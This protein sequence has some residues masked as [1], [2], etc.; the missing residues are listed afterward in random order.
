MKLYFARHG[1]SEANVQQIFWDQPH[2]YGLTDRGREQA[3]ALAD[4]LADV[5]FSALYCSPILRAAQTA[6]I[7]GRRL[8]LTPEIEDALRERASGILEGQKITPENRSWGWQV[9]Q[10]WMHGNHDARIEGGESYNDL[11]ARFMPFIRRLE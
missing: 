6:Q 4:S 5:E 3:Q 1:E 9:T 10:Q 11:V 8:N 7:V 2:G